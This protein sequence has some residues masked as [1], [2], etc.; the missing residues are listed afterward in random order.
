MSMC[1]SGVFTAARAR[2]ADSVALKLRDLVYTHLIVHRAIPHCCVRLERVRS[3]TSFPSPTGQ[4]AIA[5]LVML[6]CVSAYHLVGPSSGACCAPVLRTSFE[7]PGSTCTGSLLFSDSSPPRQ[8][9]QERCRILEKRTRVMPFIGTRCPSWSRRCAAGPRTPLPHV[10]IDCRTDIH[11]DRLC[12]HYRR[13][14]VVFTG[15]SR[16][17]GH[18]QHVHN[19]SCH[20]L[21]RCCRSRAAE[22]AS[23]PT[24]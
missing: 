15:L 3:P 13:D 12:A 8:G 19:R 24:S 2:C 7:P 16:R 6:S 21:A 18:I 20:L 1:E 10:A 23:R 9:S 4:L 11:P 5:R 22:T 17:L 14:C